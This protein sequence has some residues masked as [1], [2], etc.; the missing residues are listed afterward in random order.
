MTQVQTVSTPPSTLGLMSC[1][2]ESSPPLETSSPEI[3]RHESRRR[4]FN[5]LNGL[6]RIFRKKSR[7]SSNASTEHG[8]P[9]P[10]DSNDPSTLLVE[11]SSVRRSVAKP[12]TS[13]LSDAAAAPGIRQA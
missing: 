5:P 7:A 8:P 4:R 2:R 3:V 1:V 6:R 13:Q 12:S 11:T 9:L 10:G